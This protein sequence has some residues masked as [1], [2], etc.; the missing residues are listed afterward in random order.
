MSEPAK[1]KMGLSSLFGRSKRS[2]PGP[3]EDEDLEFSCD[4][5]PVDSKA[6]SRHRFEYRVVIY[7]Q[8]AT[9]EKAKTSVSWRPRER[10]Y[11]GFPISYEELRTRSIR[12]PLDHNDVFASGVMKTMGKDLTLGDFGP[13]WKWAGSVN[14]KPSMTNEYISKQVI[15]R[16]CRDCT[17]RK[18]QRDLLENGEPRFDENGF[19]TIPLDR[20]AYM[21]ET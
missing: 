16:R 4:N 2:P 5:F 1:S 21:L 8:Y 19:E 9:H 12:R 3:T 20:Y 18:Q 13:G 6:T 15:F 7:T 17:K 14:K 11:S 10:D